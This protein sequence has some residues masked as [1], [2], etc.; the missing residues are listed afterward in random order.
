MVLSI[1]STMGCAVSTAALD[2]PATL[3][4][5]HQ[6][7]ELD[8]LMAKEQRPVAV[9]LHA[10]WCNHCKNME[11]TTFQHKKVIQ[12]LHEK[13]YF[14]SFDG[15]QKTSVNFQQHVFHYQPTGRS[16]GTHELA[17]QLGEMDGQLVYPTFLIL[18]PKYEIVF[19]YNA[20]L[21]SAALVKILEAYL[22]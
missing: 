18:N 5:S 3:L 10:T 12:L 22:K 20:F 14:I 17:I 1:V 9:F 15:E 16:T 6:F 19:Q 7:S 21:G 13:Y 2:R 8:G 11:Q 4:V